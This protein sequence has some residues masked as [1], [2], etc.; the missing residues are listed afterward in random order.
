M[1]ISASPSLMIVKSLRSEAIVVLF[2]CFS[3]SLP[4]LSSPPISLI[5]KIDG[6][7]Y[8]LGLMDGFLGGYVTNRS[9]SERT[10]GGRGSGGG[11]SE[12]MWRKGRGFEGC[13][14]LLL[15]FFSFFTTASFRDS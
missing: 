6:F 7:V 14:L 1:R 4:V 10:W 12:G 9:F 2:V 5:I 8:V 11:G 15:Y 13:L 3:S